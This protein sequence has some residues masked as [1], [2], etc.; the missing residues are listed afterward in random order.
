VEIKLLTL[1]IP[2]LILSRPLV[3]SGSER[4]EAAFSMAKAE[5]VKREVAEEADVER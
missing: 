3:M 1:K 5:E 4:D 2:L